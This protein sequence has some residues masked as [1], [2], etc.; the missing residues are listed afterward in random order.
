MKKMIV[1]DWDGTA[2]NKNGLMTSQHLSDL[3]SKTK[4]IGV[5]Y[6]IASNT[7]LLGLQS[8]NRLFQLPSPEMLICENGAYSWHKSDDQILW[9]IDNVTRLIDDFKDLSNQIITFAINNNYDVTITHPGTY[10]LLDCKF[11]FLGKQQKGL[12]LIDK[13]LVTLTVEVRAIKPDG[14]LTARRDLTEEIYNFLN[15]KIFEDVFALKKL[16]LEV[17]MGENGWIDVTFDQLFCNKKKALV[18]IM[19]KNL[20]TKFFYIGDGKN[21]IP[22]AMCTDF[23]SIAVANACK[24]LKDIAAYVTKGKYTEGLIEAIE[25]IVSGKIK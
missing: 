8:Y 11:P 14:S 5:G 24:E 4:Q 18:E 12:I 6:G 21:D 1:F 13:R 10:L 2:T 15:K 19:K 17:E 3:L 20:D 7:S 22:V 25:G 9:H 16:P 23:T